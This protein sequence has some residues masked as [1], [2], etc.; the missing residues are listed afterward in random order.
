[1]LYMGELKVLEDSDRDTCIAENG[2][3]PITTDCVDIDKWRFDQV[4]LQEQAGL[5]GDARAV[6]N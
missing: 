3:P 4:R 2:R 1:M 6:D 5:S